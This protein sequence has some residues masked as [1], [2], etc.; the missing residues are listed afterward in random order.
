MGYTV[1]M[2]V[3]GG[4][5][6]YSYKSATRVDV[7]QNHLFLYDKLDNVLVVFQSGWWIKANKNESG[8]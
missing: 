2:L 8:D 3:K 7:K 1:T 6:E 4:L 5:V